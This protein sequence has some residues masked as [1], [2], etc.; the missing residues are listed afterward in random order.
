LRS[1]I[2]VERPVEAGGII[3]LGRDGLQQPIYSTPKQIAID[4]ELLAMAESV[5]RHR[6][7]TARCSSAGIKGCRP[8]RPTPRWRRQRR[9]RF[10]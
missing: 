9:P 10:P 3:E 1:P 5:A 7:R 2:R 4:R 8:S 6:I